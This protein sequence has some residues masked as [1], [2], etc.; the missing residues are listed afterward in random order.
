MRN[1]ILEDLKNAMK[2]QDKE[3]LARINPKANPFSNQLFQI[4]RRM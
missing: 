3:K 1:Q 4:H 2:A